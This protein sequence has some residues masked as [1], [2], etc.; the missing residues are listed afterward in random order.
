MTKIVQEKRSDMGAYDAQEPRADG[1]APGFSLPRTYYKDPSIFEQEK[2]SIL[3]NT[4]IYAGHASEIPDRGDY[5]V[6]SML[7]ESAIIVRTESNRI[8]A[9]YNVCRHRGSTIC[10]ESCGNAKR[11]TCP[12]HAW[13]YNLEGQLVSARDMPDGF[14][15]SDITLHPCAIDV[16]DGLI[17]VNFSDKPTALDEAKRDLADPM[18]IYGF[19]N[20]KVAAKKHYPIAA[21][22]KVTLENYQECYHCAPSHPEYAQSHT[23]KV[24][25]DRFDALQKPMLERMAACGIRHYEVDRQFD[26]YVE[27]QEQYAYSRYALF[28]GFKTGS[29][30]GNPVAP[31]LGS[32]TGYDHGASDISIGALSYFL[33]YNDHVVTYVFTPTGHETSACD[34]SWL[35]RNDAVEG[36]DYDLER[37]TWL[38][39]VTTQADERIIVDTQRG[40]NSRKYQPGPLSKMEFLIERYIKWYLAELAEGETD[41]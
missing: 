2:T 19:A 34:I 27:G 11:L 28:E 25:S 7:D 33:A 1:S 17:F 14:D 31:L 3:Y 23:L 18:D 22:W 39:D 29:R 40:I 20:M 6:F 12:Y 37:L 16:I 5:F 26:A 36:Q 15:T 24:E 30:D 8:T 4:W 13:T 10:K 32:I 35:V 9:H 41:R 38:W 21:N